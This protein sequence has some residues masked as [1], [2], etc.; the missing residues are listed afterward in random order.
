MALNFGA[1]LSA[2]FMFDLAALVAQEVATRVA[3]PCLLA[4]CRACEAEDASQLAAKHA[5][6]PWPSSRAEAASALVRT[7]NAVCAAYARHALLR[8]MRVAPVAMAA[9]GHVDASSFL[10]ALAPL[11]LDMQP[12]LPSA[13]RAA[14]ARREPALIRAQAALQEWRVAVPDV[15]VLLNSLATAA[16]DRIQAAASADAAAA[17]AATEHSEAAA[18]GRPRLAS[19]AAISM[20]AWL[21]EAACMPVQHASALRAAAFESTLAV[22]AM[23]LPPLLSLLAVLPRVQ[24][25]VPAA[26]ALWLAELRTAA[27]ALLES[28]HQTGCACWVVDAALCTSPTLDGAADAQETAEGSKNGA[29]AAAL[30]AL[31]RADAVLASMVARTPLPP[32]FVARMAAP[33]AR[34]LHPTCGIHTELDARVLEGMTVV[35]RRSYSHATRRRHL[36]LPAG[37]THTH[38]LVA[39]CVRGSAQLA[40]AAVAPAAVAL[41]RTHSQTVATPTPGAPDCF[42]Y[43]VPGLSF[44]FADTSVLRLDQADE[45]RGDRRL[46]WHL[47]SDNFGEEESDDSDSSSDT[48]SD[49]GT[50]NG[51]VRCGGVRGLQ[52]PAGAEWVKCV[53]AFTPGDVA[54]PAALSGAIGTLP[55]PPVLAGFGV[56]MDNGAWSADADAMLLRAA[57]LALPA[58]A[59]IAAATPS[60]VFATRVP[61][62]QARLA[63]VV[64]HRMDGTAH[65]D[66]A[67][68]SRGTPLVQA[69]SVVPYGLALRP[70]EQ[71][72]TPVQDVPLS[73]RSPAALAGRLAVLQ[74]LS[75]LATPGLHLCL[76]PGSRVGARLL[77]FK[78]RLMPEL[79]ATAL[80]QALRLTAPPGGPHNTPSVTIARGAAA[81]A[82]APEH[83][84]FGQL[85]RQLAGATFTSATP[86]SRLWHTRLAGEAAIDQG[87]PF[88]DT[89]RDLA[90]E[91]C[92]E[93]LASAAAS[94]LRLFV[95]VRNATLDGAFGGDCFLPAVAPHSAVQL[96]S[97]E[98]L[99]R[100]MGGCLR[101]DNPL[102]L[103]LAPPVWKALLGE[104][105][106]SLHDLSAC[107]EAQAKHLAAMASCARD[108]WPAQLTWDGVRDHAGRLYA[109]AAARRGAPLAWEQRHTFVAVVAAAHAD[110]WRPA[111][112]AMRR[113]L[114][115]EVSCAGLALL[116]W[117]DLERRVCGERAVTLAALREITRSSIVGRRQEPWLWTILGDMSDAQR[118]AFLAFATGRSRLPALPRAG[119]LVID[120]DGPW[121]T[122]SGQGL[123]LPT[124]STCGY[125][126]HTPHAASLEQLRDGI[127]YAIT[128]CRA[129]DMD[130]DPH[131]TMFS[132]LGAA[133]HGEAGVAELGAEAG[134][135]AAML[136]LP[137]FGAAEARAE[138][139]AT[140]APPEADSDDDG[141][142]ARLR[143]P[144]PRRVDT[145]AEFMRRLF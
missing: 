28:P 42:W 23:P 89:L 3:A 47:T 131:G 96:R 38:V 48:D 119:Q 58:G 29:G 44:G 87:G 65:A 78:N 112:D 114:E 8:V 56:S 111:A 82:T 70:P 5:A 106:D 34:A 46:S 81:L 53:Y 94:A 145:A 125:T 76:Q 110:A 75:A 116:T 51:G 69:Q 80:Q 97:F 138:E 6:M 83:T 61:L 144:L 49:D 16:A 4:A 20:A 35:Y 32:W 99:G 122:A 62:A 101:I 123:L 52:G 55:P 79:A 104:R 129:I 13:Y 137:L 140:A 50:L 124:A 30:L 139:A 128:N 37:C 71:A 33:R 113:G 67:P 18:A 90:V 93:D 107:D 118:G 98:F 100:L 85:Q 60:Q 143:V 10:A 41:A 19:A 36:R 59:S 121:R 22:Y 109:A 117:R 95:R 142:V 45:L 11:F 108:S 141:N 1:N 24:T 126:F 43:C 17:S 2:P 102:E 136:L 86:G 84:V 115:A 31:R 73:E 25:D 134:S 135:G 7:E 103:T 68:H 91:L 21:C 133:P 74:H 15:S 92:A 72:S 40:L 57:A 130:G 63:R 27:A 9:A 77:A 54:V 26:H 105:C 132:Q 88:R 39:G 66:P 64:S 120:M 14:A 127:M 12:H